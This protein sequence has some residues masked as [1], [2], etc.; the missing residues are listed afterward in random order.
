MSHSQLSHYCTVRVLICSLPRVWVSVLWRSWPQH[1]APRWASPILSPVHS[2]ATGKCPLPKHLLLG[3]GW[4]WGSTGLSPALLC[5]QP[6][7]CLTALSMAWLPLLLE[8]SRRWYQKKHS[9][10]LFS[11]QCTGWSVISVSKSI[12]QLLLNSHH[13]SIYSGI[14]SLGMG[15]WWVYYSAE[16]LINRSDLLV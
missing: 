4:T 6:P 16:Q 3:S 10:P 9:F 8:M 14:N 1:P 15:L 11:I 2:R 7:C 13:L 12:Y 5:M